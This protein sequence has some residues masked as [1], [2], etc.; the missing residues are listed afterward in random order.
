MNQSGQA[1]SIDVL[2]QQ[3]THCEICPR[4]RDHCR[5][6][7][8]VKRRAFLKWDYW[9]KPVPS[10]GDPSARLLLIGLA[11]AAHGANRTGRMFTGDSSGDFLYSA[12]H[13]AGFVVKTCGLGWIFGGQSAGGE[14]P[15]G[16]APRSGAKH[17]PAQLGFLLIT[18]SVSLPS[19]QQRESQSRP[20][21]CRLR[22]TDSLSA[23]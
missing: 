12:L 5:T 4:L 11:P 17:R 22:G 19:D 6:I 9:G 2:Q 7:A 21:P 15:E 8:E 18:L 13:R 20:K 1:R 16:R 3:V 23:L 14:P 10:F